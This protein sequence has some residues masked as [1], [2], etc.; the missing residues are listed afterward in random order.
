VF[1]SWVRELRERIG[2]KQSEVEDHLN[3][4]RGF[5]NRLESGATPPDRST[6]DILADAL[7]V[8]PDELWERAAPERLRGLDEDLADWHREKLKAASEFVLAPF[9]QAL[10]EGIRAQLPDEKER[11][12]AVLLVGSIVLNAGSKPTLLAD[13]ASWV[14]EEAGYE[15]A[16]AMLQASEMRVHELRYARDEAVASWRKAEHAV[17]EAAKLEAEARQIAVRAS[18][19]PDEYRDLVSALNERSGA[20]S[21][22]RRQVE[23]EAAEIQRRLAVIED[24]LQQAQAV[25]AGR[26]QLVRRIEADR[27]SSALARRR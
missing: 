13:A 4:G 23:E 25:L 6:C 16:R 11:A 26:A 1:G 19:I 27:R 10:I 20:M 21:E 17:V 22:R 24:E 2:V 9:E 14:N 8:D 12:A 5:M 3:K 18:Q 7:G 15:N